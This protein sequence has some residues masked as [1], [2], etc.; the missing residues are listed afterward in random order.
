MRGDHALG[1]FVA[2]QVPISL[3]SGESEFYALLRAA[4][5]AKFLKN[6]SE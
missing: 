3:S 1:E 6:L 5:E 4:V 2:T